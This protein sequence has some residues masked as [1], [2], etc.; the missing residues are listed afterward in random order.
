MVRESHKKTLCYMIYFMLHAVSAYVINLHICETHG[1]GIY[2]YGES[3][4][5]CVGG[6]VHD[7]EYRVGHVVSA[8]VCAVTVQCRGQRYGCQSLQTPG[9]LVSLSLSASMCLC[10]SLHPT[11]P[12]HVLLT[13]RETA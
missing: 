3:S 4:F 6:T 11:C 5:V 8:V 10:L 2:T 7:S 9:M 1:H 12:L 13:I